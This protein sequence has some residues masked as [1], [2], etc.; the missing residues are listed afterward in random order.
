MRTIDAEMEPGNWR[1]HVQMSDMDV[2]CSQDDRPSNALASGMY[3]C[4][5]LDRSCLPGAPAHKMPRRKMRGRGSRLHPCDLCF[6]GINGESTRKSAGSP[7][8]VDRRT[9]ANSLHSTQ[10]TACSPRLSG[11]Q[12]PCCDVEDSDRGTNDPPQGPQMEHLS[13]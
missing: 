1:S 2:R 7:T 10:T 12:G 6:P 4:H 13:T 9:R 8:K 11:N 5:R 3:A